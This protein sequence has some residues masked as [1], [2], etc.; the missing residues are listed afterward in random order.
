M[1]KSTTIPVLL[2]RAG[3]TTWDLA[4]RLG[5]ACDLPVCPKGAA[6][7][8][9]ALKIA[10]LSHVAAVITGPDEASRETGRILAKKCSA[11]FRAVEG[12]HEVDV[13]LWE[14]LLPTELEEKFPTAYRQWM[15]DPSTV[16]V[17]GGEGVGEASDRIIGAFARAIERSADNGKAII[18][19]LKPI[20]RGLVLCWLDGV[21]LTGL[22]S[23]VE[24]A[25]VTECR[26]VPRTLLEER[27]E[28]SR[29]SA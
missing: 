24:R 7:V 29:V 6:E 26:Q 4:G 20:A 19:V 1:A 10:D 14:G 15:E 5:G 3:S 22:W 23:V 28:G 16:V 2:V 13:G 18:V 12:L 27:R 21:A 11:K 8:Q 25:A 17:P 9:A